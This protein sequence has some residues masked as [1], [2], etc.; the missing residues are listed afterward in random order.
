MSASQSF[1]E[2]VIAST[3]LSTFFA[4]SV[5]DRACKRA[6]VDPASLDA[7]GLAS[8]LESLEAAL[9][10]YLPAG[11]LPARMAALRALAGGRAA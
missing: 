7:R 8:A 6:S 3:G 4:A 1:R 11:E 2:R 9:K 10:L 5:V